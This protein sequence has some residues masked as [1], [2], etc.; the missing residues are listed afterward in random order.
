M[1]K[2][3]LQSLHLDPSHAYEQTAW[4]DILYGIGTINKGTQLVIIQGK[5]FLCSSVPFCLIALWILTNIFSHVFYLQGKA[6]NTMGCICCFENVLLCPSREF[7]SDFKTVCVY[8]NFSYA[9]SIC[10][11]YKSV[12]SNLFIEI[13]FLLGHLEIGTAT[14]FH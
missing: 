10:G 1:I 14:L 3:I 11:V 13:Y 2:S 7:H 8:I 5:R 6:V 4:M 9:A 12:F